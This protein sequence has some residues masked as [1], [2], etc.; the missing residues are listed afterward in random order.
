[1]L[2]LDIKESLLGPFLRPNVNTMKLNLEKN[3][4]KTRGVHLDY[5]HG[6]K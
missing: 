1:M 3:L 2:N 6:H 4:K 5:F